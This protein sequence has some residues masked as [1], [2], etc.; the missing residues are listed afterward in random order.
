MAIVLSRS[1]DDIHASIDAFLAERIERNVQA[2][3]LFHARAGRVSGNPPLY[4]WQLDA[5][6]RFFA[7]RIPPWPLLVADL[8]PMLARPLRRP[9]S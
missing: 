9:D 4:G 2:T 7:L 8:D 5:E 3:L 6:P 1:T